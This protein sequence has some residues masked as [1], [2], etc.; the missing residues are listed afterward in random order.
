MAPILHGS[1]L[2]ANVQ[3][4]QPQLLTGPA[5]AR[6]VLRWVAKTIGINRMCVRCTLLHWS[7]FLRDYSIR[8]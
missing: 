7:E 3:P 1:G 6:D 8:S 5:L 2:R 4:R